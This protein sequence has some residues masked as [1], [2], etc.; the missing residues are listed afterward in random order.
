MKEDGK[1]EVSFR[2]PASE[3]VDL[4]KGLQTFGFFSGGRSVCVEELSQGTSCLP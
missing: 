1:I 2:I 3:L 4:L